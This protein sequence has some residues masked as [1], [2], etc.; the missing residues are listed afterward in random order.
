M[1]VSKV[2]VDGVTLM[3]VTVDT[4]ASNNLLTGAQATKNDGQKV[5]GTFDPSG[6]FTIDASL[7][8]TYVSATEAIAFN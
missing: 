4:V 8:A 1:A 2:I 3:D 6:S 7:T 5:T